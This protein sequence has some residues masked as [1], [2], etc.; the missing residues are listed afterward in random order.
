MRKR[1]NSLENNDSTEFRDELSPKL[2]SFLNLN[3]K[4]IL[5]KRFSMNYQATKEA[6]SLN[7]RNLCQIALMS[8]YMHEKSDI[9][10][11][12]QC[13]NNLTLTCL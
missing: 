8:N 11:K 7:A 6:R 10:L 4:L 12:R 1:I 2:K 9:L 5:T 3:L 13:Y